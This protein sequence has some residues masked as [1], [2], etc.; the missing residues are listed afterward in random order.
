[1]VGALQGEGIAGIAHL[2]EE[3]GAHVGGVVPVQELG[4]V[5]PDPQSA[6]LLQK[7]GVWD[8]DI[9][10]EELGGG[11]PAE[12]VEK[13][14]EDLVVH[15]EPLVP[16]LIAGEPEPGHPVAVGPGLP[17]GG[18]GGD[19]GGEGGVGLLQEGPAE[20]LLTCG[21][22]G[23]V[24]LGQQGVHSRLRRGAVHVA[25]SGQGRVVLPDALEE[26]EGG[27]A[28][29]EI[30]VFVDGH[31]A[32]QSDGVRVEVFGAQLGPVELQGPLLQN[33]V[34]G[35]GGGEE[36][37]HPVL[38]GHVPGV[39]GDGGGDDFGGGGG[40]LRFRGG[41]LVAGHHGAQGAHAQQ[42]EQDGDRSPPPGSGT[43]VPEP[44]LQKALA[45]VELGGKPGVRRAH[46][47]PSFRVSTG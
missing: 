16:L 11:L 28:V 21:D 45:A 1:M 3:Q 26:E 24:G 4:R 22:Q 46:T 43:Q 27:L 2:G 20:E 39:V 37:A 42:G 15:P 29:E 18:G 35:P 8:V 30:A 12:P 32:R 47:E 33:V 7:E 19:E 40:R 5:G 38:S 17:L 41:G 6:S 9:G 34:I 23:G 31:A 10:L 36:L 14:A 25:G 13:T 44:E